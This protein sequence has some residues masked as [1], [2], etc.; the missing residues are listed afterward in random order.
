MI[1]GRNIRTGYSKIQRDYSQVELQM[2][3]LQNGPLPSGVRPSGVRRG[4]APIW[5]TQTKNINL[6]KNYQ[7]IF[8]S[9]FS[10]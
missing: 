5:K 7:T 6:K 8:Q 10:T 9:L 4:D 3:E 1:S 2:V